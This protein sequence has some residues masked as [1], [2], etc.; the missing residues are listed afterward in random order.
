MKILLFPGSFDPFHSGHINVIQAANKQFNFDKLFLILSKNS[1]NKKAIATVEQRLDMLNLGLPYCKCDIEINDYEFT[2]SKSGYTIETIRYFKEIFP[3]DDLYLL[4]G[5]DQVNVFN[6]WKEA[7]E[8]EDLVNIIYYDRPGY[9]ETSPNIVKYN[10][11]KVNGFSRDIS[12]TDIR[13]LNK[14]DAP[15]PILNYI[16][17][18]KLYFARDVYNLLD[19]RRYRHSMSV[20]NL[21]YEI[22][23][24]NGYDKLKAKAFMVGLLHDIGKYADITELNT[25]MHE[26]FSEFIDLPVYAYHQFVGSYYAATQFNILDSDIINAIKYHC[27]GRNGMSVLEK[28]VYVADKIDPLRGYDSKYMIDLCKANITGGFIYVLS[29]NIEF[30]MNKHKEKDNYSD[31][32]LT[33]DCVDDY[34]NNKHHQEREKN[35]DAR[36][37]Y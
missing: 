1:V 28:I 3:N 17:L 4:I 31:N 27:T 21:C 14:L 24:A 34:L 8:I 13:N 15:L 16:T 6:A 29:Q 25:I 23:E 33:A 10:M 37:D 11:M 2:K 18:H 19:L 36:F 35:N 9:C 22:A 30:N 12:S 32:R 7:K 5:L 26:Y 20:A